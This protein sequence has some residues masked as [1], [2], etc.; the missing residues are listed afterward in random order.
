MKWVDRQ[1]DFQFSVAESPGLIE[2]LRSTPDELEA[3]VSS[4][5]REVLSRRDGSTW[6]IQENAGHLLIAESL[7]LGRLDDY[8]SDSETLRPADMTN[9]RT[10]DAKHNESDISYI[11]AGFRRQRGELVKRLEELEPDGFAKSA[12]HPRLQKQM[13]VCDM[14]YFQ[15]EHD[16]HH[17]VRIR[18]LIKRFGTPSENA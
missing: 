11:L 14:M 4:L 10:Y 16:R 13:R 3:L 12:I 7:F 8:G 9:R 1:F 6:S 5:P 15:A 17:L 2:R 18:E